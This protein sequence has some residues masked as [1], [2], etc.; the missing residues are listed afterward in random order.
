VGTPGLDRGRSDYPMRRLEAA[1]EWPIWA[2]ASLT[3]IRSVLQ[4]RLQGELGLTRLLAT[5]ISPSA[6]AGGPVLR[7]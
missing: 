5:A 2:T 7:R 4:R 6:A 1:S 3:I